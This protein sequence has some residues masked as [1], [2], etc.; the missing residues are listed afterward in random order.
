VSAL[1]NH[2]FGSAFDIDAVDNG[3]GSVPA[4]CGRRGATREL[5]ASANALG[6]YWGG[7]F[8][9]QDGMHFEISKL[10]VV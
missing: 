8:G 1:S 4:L 5:V 2:S 3:F 10:G 7:H 6:V 9:R